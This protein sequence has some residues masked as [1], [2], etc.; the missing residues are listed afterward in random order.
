[1]IRF[2][3]SSSALKEYVSEHNVITWSGPYGMGSLLFID[4]SDLH[5]VFGC[6][7]D[8]ESWCAAGSPVQIS[9]F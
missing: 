9:L 7:S 5:V 2:F 1:M 3:P 4:S 6:R 8:Y